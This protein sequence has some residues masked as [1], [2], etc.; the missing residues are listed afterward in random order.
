MVLSFVIENNFKTDSIGQFYQRLREKTL[1]RQV[2]NLSSH[3]NEKVEK[4]ESN[5]LLS[6]HPREP[7]DSAMTVVVGQRKV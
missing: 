2:L 6:Q 4:R 7:A 5:D 3:V 1:S